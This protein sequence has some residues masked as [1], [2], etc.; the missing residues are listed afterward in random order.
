MRLLYFLDGMQYRRRKIC[1][2]VF[3]IP[4]KYLGLNSPFQEKNTG[5]GQMK[6]KLAFF[7]RM[8]FFSRAVHRRRSVQ[9]PRNHLKWNALQH[10]RSFILNLSGIPDTIL[11]G[12]R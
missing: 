10:A 2:P 4:E 6:L 1:S 11:T 5:M 8:I 12:V 7:L 9:D 3:I